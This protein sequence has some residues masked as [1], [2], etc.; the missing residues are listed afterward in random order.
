[1]LKNQ[2]KIDFYKTKKLE[3]AKN[4]FSLCIKMSI[5]VN[6][7]K[8]FFCSFLYISMK[9]VIRGEKGKIYLL[10]F[11]NFNHKM[12]LESEASRRYFYGRGK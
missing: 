10:Q 1:M 7:T 11:E 5:V 3:N 6:R 12:E 4:C 2:R 8:K 9:L